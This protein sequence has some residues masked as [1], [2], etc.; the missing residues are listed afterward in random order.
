M[1]QIQIPDRTVRDIIYSP[2]CAQCYGSRY[3][4]G[5][6]GKMI[7]IGAFAIGD[8]DGV[9]IEVRNR[10]TILKKDQLVRIIGGD[11]QAEFV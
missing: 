5:Q 8:I 2:P 6:K 7:S 1:P 4:A 3:A 10:G 9:C 11:G